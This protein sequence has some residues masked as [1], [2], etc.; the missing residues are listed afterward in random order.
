[1]WDFIPKKR[2]KI[3]DEGSRRVEIKPKSKEDDVHIEVD[4]L[5]ESE[6]T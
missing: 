3:E 4:L 6:A 2:Q 5:D 1:M